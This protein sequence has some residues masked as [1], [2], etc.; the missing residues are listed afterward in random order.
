MGDIILFGISID[1]PRINKQL[2]Y[3]HK[4]M[5]GEDIVEVG[6]AK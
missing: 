2:D 6:V 1:I 4:A 5:S 3:T